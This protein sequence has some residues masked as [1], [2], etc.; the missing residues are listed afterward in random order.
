[1]LRAAGVQGTI[2]YGIFFLKSTVCREHG[3]AG[4]A[5]EM[6]QGLRALAALA[7]ELDPISTTWTVAHN[8]L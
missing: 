1:V 7:E 3:A 4:E 8:C 6:A 2:H 5:G